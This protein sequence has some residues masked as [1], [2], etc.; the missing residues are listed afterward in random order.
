MLVVEIQ[1]KSRD[2]TIKH[3]QSA[4]YMLIFLF[5]W[6]LAMSQRIRNKSN[7]QFLQKLKKSIFCLHVSSYMNL[8]LFLLIVG[9]V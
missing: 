2:F 1:T 8:S 4:I 9:M 3:H 7:L 6:L 5:V